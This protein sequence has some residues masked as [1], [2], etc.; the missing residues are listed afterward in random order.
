[1]PFGIQAPATP[2]PVRETVCGLPDALSFTVTVPV[3][4]PVATGVNVISIVQLAPEGRLDPHVCVSEKG[5]LAVML[6]RLRV[7]VP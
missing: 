5:V 4:L 6:N 7:A 3:M 1:M 2:V